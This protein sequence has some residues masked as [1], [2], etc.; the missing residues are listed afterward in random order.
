[1]RG[2]AARRHAAHPRRHQRRE[3]RRAHRPGPD[4]GKDSPRAPALF[5]QTF[6]PAAAGGAGHYGGIGVKAGSIL[7]R[8]VSEFCG[9][10]M[11]AAALI[12]LIALATYVPTDP[13]WFFSAGSGAAP[14]NF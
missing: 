3:H 1:Q 4:Q 12:W 14:A 6:W 13:A 2:D 8:R 10:T 7:S 9:V 5:P 11:F